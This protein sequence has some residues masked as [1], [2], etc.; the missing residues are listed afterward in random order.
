[1]GGKATS[2]MTKEKWEEERETHDIAQD[3]WEFLEIRREERK[4]IKV[5]LFSRRRIKREEKEIFAYMSCCC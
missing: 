1:M 4:K 2:Q 3:F 5:S